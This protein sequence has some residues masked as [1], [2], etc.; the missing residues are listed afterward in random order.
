MDPGYPFNDLL[1]LPGRRQIA[2]PVRIAD[3][4]V[5]VGDIDPL[6]VRTERIEG[7]A[8]R[9]V[10][11]TGKDFVFGR[12]AAA[13]RNAKDAHRIG[14]AVGN[15]QVAI[16]RYAND[17]RPSETGGHHLDRKARRSVRLGAGRH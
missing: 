17:A 3:D 9:L 11:P 13:G 14:C 5:A 4:T 12:P 15:E 10:E 2:I 7:D 8:I 6:G 16:R 1:G